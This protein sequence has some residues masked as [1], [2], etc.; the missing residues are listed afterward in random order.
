MKDAVVGQVA[1]S[2]AGRDQ[3]RMFVITRIIDEQ[4]VEIVDGALRKLGKPK[5]KKRKHLDV[6][7]IVL[8]PVGSKLREGKRVFDAEIR[9]S[10]EANSR[11]GGLQANKEA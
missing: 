11:Q 4:Y 6:S 8:E 9:S 5:K 7:P 10:L 3:G 1:Y 2:K